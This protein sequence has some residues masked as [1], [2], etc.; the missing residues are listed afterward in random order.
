VGVCRRFPV[1]D[2]LLVEPD[3]ALAS[4]RLAERGPER[5]PGG[6]PGRFGS[7]RTPAP[8]FRAPA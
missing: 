3:S 4:S 5:C 6:R 8:P 7:F 1:N 2:R